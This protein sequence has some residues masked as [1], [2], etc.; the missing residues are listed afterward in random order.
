MDSAQRRRKIRRDIREVGP[1]RMRSK[2]SLNN[3][4]KAGCGGTSSG[5]SWA[6][7]LGVGNQEKAKIPKCKSSEGALGETEAD[8]SYPGREEAA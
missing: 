5:G 2:G 3:N 7:G 4:H 8:A 6:Q 1:A